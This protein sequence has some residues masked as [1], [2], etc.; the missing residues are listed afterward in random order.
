MTRRKM[1][2]RVKRFWGILLMALFGVAVTV[3]MWSTLASCVVVLGHLPL[4]FV[5]GIALTV[6]GLLGLPWARD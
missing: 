5:N 3:L 2:R 4:L 1:Y 6:G